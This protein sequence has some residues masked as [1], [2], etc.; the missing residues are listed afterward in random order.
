VEGG[1]LI[2]ILVGMYN[3]V[4]KKNRNMDGRD[5]A[6]ERKRDDRRKIRLSVSF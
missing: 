5:D 2:W 3:T 4:G 6:D 1:E